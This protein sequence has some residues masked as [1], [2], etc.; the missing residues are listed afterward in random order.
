MLEINNISKTYKKG[1]EEFIALKDVTL[2]IEKGEYIVVSGASG[3]GKS[4]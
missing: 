2:K 3:A 4:T 1:P